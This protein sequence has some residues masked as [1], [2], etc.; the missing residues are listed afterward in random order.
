MAAGSD[1]SPRNPPRRSSQTTGADGEGGVEVEGAAAVVA[2]RPLQTAPHRAHPDC[3]WTHNAIDL[4]SFRLGIS[5]RD[6]QF[7][8]NIDPIVCALFVVD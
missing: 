4:S 3:F 1:A 8:G 5:W 6:I 2:G 7:C